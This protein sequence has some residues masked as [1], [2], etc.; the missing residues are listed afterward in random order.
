MIQFGF[1]LKNDEDD[2]QLR[3]INFA[4]HTWSSTFIRDTWA[5]NTL[6]RLNF[7]CSWHDRYFLPEIKTVKIHIRLRIRW[8]MNRNLRISA[9]RILPY[10]WASRNLLVIWFLS[11]C[12][13]QSLCSSIHFFFFRNNFSN[14]KSQVYVVFDISTIKHLQ[15]VYSR[16]ESCW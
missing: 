5:T 13:Y 14:C 6:A 4:R 8:L 2:I 9:N 1:V 15:F 11:L 7:K 16:D 3:P 10:H 12:A